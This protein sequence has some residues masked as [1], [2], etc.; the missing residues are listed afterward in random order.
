MKLRVGVDVKCD[1]GAAEGEEQ[2]QKG[3]IQSSSIK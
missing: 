3:M 2:Q 1:G